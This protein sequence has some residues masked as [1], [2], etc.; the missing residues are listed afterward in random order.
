MEH[1]KNLGGLFHIDA[2]ENGTDRIK[3]QF[4]SGAV[5]LYTYA[6]AGSINIEQM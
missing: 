2:Y 6:S 5:Y 4:K 1:Y 3:A